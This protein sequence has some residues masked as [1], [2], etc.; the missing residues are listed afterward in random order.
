MG[1]V[2][3]IRLDNFPISTNCV[4]NAQNILYKLV[5]KI[6]DKGTVNQIKT[7]EEGPRSS[8]SGE[9]NGW[10]LDAKLKRSNRKMFCVTGIEKYLRQYG[11]SVRFM[12]SRGEILK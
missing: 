11:E 6:R 7:A 8:V 10:L 4:N 3:L 9:L 12:F 1:K 2:D 5:Y